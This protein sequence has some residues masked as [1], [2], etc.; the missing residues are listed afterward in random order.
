MKINKEKAERIT[1]LPDEEM[2]CEILK[3]AKAYGLSLPERTPS[4]SDLE[5]IRAIASSGKVNMG[6]AM[7]MV[8]DLKR[9]A[10]NG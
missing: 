7:K 1:R 8:N 5:K 4:H 10:G 6:D 3:L 9:S 2:W